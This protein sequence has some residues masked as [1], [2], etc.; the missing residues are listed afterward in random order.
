MVTCANNFMVGL[1]TTLF[2]FSIFGLV[3]ARERWGKIL[4]PTTPIG[5]TLMIAG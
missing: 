3:L 5:G 1:G 2:S 4:G